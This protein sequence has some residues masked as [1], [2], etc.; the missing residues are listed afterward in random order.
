MLHLFK[1]LLW[2]HTRVLSVCRLIQ[3]RRISYTRLHCGFISAWLRTKQSLQGGLFLLGEFRNL[4]DAVARDRLVVV[5]MIITLIYRLR[6][7]KWFLFHWPRRRPHIHYLRFSQLICRLLE[8]L[9]FVCTLLLYNGAS[10]GS[11]NWYLWHSILMIGIE[12]LA[13]SAGLGP[14]YAIVITIKW[15]SMVHVI[16]KACYFLFSLL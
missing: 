15:I 4:R 10:I 2:Y 3:G 6:K 7:I 11:A 14:W 5:A 12:F 13:L 1:M 8:Y 16:L 9:F